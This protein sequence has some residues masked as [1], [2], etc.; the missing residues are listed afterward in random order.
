[1]S[2]LN[3]L[4]E[5]K[6]VEINRSTGLVAGHILAQFPY[7][8]DAAVTVGGKDFLQNGVI[9][10]L[11]D[12]L[13]LGDFSPALHSQPFLVYTEELVTFLSGNKYFANVEDYEGDIIPRAIGLFVG[14]AFTT[15]NFTGTGAFAAVVDG[16]L[17]RQAS[18]AGASFVVQASTIPTGEVGAKFTYIGIPAQAAASALVATHAAL[19]TGVHGLT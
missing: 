9:V 11:N 1:M 19:T 4:P 16:V 14:D 5:F 18:V 12:D 3:Y 6:V 8:G 15:N 7:D 2:I 10:G 13:T 17:T